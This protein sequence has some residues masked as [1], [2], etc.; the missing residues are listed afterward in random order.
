[1]TTMERDA[2][3]ENQEPIHPYASYGIERFTSLIDFETQVF[4][5]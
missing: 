4:G 3:N 5:K 1:M 2:E